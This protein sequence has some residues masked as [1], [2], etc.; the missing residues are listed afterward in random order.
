[1]GISGNK[2]G[3]KLK[4]VKTYSNK[5]L[6]PFFHNKVSKGQKEGILT[7]NR[8]RNENSSTK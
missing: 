3:Q 2:K 6:L 1:M 4:T 5:Q 8:G 7:V